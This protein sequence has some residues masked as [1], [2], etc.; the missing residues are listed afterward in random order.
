MPTFGKLKC[1]Q[2][3]GAKILKKV[4]PMPKPQ[5]LKRMAIS[6]FGKSG[7]LICCNTHIWVS[8]QHLPKNYTKYVHMV[9]LLVAYFSSTL[10]STIVRSINYLRKARFFLTQNAKLFILFLSEKVVCK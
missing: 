1:L 3:S 8:A 10:P 2:C 5:S 4:V 9:V 6:F 7:V